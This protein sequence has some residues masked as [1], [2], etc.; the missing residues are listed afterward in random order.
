MSAR[1]AEHRRNLRID[2]PIVGILALSLILNTVGISYGLPYPAP[3]EWLPPGD[4]SVIW[5]SDTI[6][7]IG[8]LAAAKDLF[9][10]GPW[11]RSE[12][13]YPLA[14]YILLS[15]T[16]APCMAYWVLTGDFQ[17]PTGPGYPYGFANPTRALTVLTVLTRA[18]AAAMGTGIVLA[19]YQIGKEVFGRRAGIFAALS[20]AVCNLLIFYAHT[21]NVDVPYVFWSMLALWAYVRL[22]RVGQLKHYALLGILMALA[23]ATKVQAY[24]LFLLLPVP[25]VLAHFRHHHRDPASLRIRPRITCPFWSKLRA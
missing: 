22:V 17:R 2:R 21:E 9:S 20:M 23:S 14:H 18:V 5:T 1:T 25:V 6:A 12:Y 24:G 13:T 3:A 16:Y 10:W 11:S 19:T 15:V 4:N 8:P 7:P